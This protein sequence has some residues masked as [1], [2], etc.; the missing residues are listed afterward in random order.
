MQRRI[1]WNLKAHRAALRLTQEQLGELIDRSPKY[2]G[3]IEQGRRNLTL[4]ALEQL[5]D[6][7]YLDPADLLQP[8]PV[9]APP[10]RPPW[11]RPDSSRAKP[12]SIPAGWT[13]SFTPA[14][15]DAL[16]ATFVDLAGRQLAGPHSAHLGDYQVVYRIDND[17]HI[18]V[19]HRVAHRRDAYRS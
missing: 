10:A 11:P 13:V 4:K 14:A 18:V 12:Q 16:T 9:T 19:V 15:A 2:I 7:L 5:S 6:D 1:A 17:R 3:F 8:V